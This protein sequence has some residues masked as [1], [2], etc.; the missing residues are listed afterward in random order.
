MVM[1]TGQW[2][3]W[4]TAKHAM[5][6]GTTSNY[7]DGGRDGRWVGAKANTIIDT[8]RR[9]PILPHYPTIS[10]CLTPPHACNVQLASSARYAGSEADEPRQTL[11]GTPN[12][13]HPEAKR[14]NNDRQ[15]P[16]D[17][18]QQGKKLPTPDRPL[19]VA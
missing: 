18:V 19:G 6:D 8:G 2:M 1:V 17:E 10:L 12:G 5:V 7:G 16:A 15:M 4:S 13:A 9:D 11:R 14:A 3:R